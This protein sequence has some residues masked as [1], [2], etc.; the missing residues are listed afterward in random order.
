MK[1]KKE[2]KKNKTKWETEKSI[3]VQNGL[4]F[5]R[6]SN[7]TE[8]NLT[9]LVPLWRQEGRFIHKNHLLRGKMKL[10]WVK[11]AEQEEKTKYHN[12]TD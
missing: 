8:I 10:G 1:H 4:Y 6:R 7:R 12:N 2:K 9:K 5:G 11:N 3:T